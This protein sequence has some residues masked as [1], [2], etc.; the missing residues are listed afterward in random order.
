M[1]PRGKPPGIVGPVGLADGV[2]VAV[3][4]APVGVADG[5]GVAVG[6]GVGPV[7]VADGVG[8]AVGVG[9][10]PAWATADQTVTAI[11]IIT[12]VPTSGR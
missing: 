3:G 1:P 7:G 8:V 6:V 5:V 10:G 2:G 9:V 11:A 12:R 4:V